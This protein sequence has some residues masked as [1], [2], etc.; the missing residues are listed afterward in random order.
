MTDDKMVLVEDSWALI[1]YSTNSK[2]LKF[3]VKIVL[4]TLHKILRLLT[5]TQISPLTVIHALKDI[6]MYMKCDFKASIFFFFFFFLF[7][8]LEKYQ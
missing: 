8:F 7:F 1:I 5:W 6:S 4:V 3:I 2:V